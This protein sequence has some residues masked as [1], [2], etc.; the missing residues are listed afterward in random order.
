[1]ESA[2]EECVKSLLEK[3]QKIGTPG[4]LSKAVKRGSAALVKMV[5]DR[6]APANAGDQY[7]IKPLETALNRGS[8]RLL[9]GEHGWVPEIPDNHEVIALLLKA[10]AD[11]KTKNAQG[12]S[13]FG[14]LMGTGSD[15]KALHAMLDQG[16][17]PSCYCARSNS[18]FI[19]FFYLFEGRWGKDRHALLER[20]LKT[21]AP[22]DARYSDGSGGVIQAA[23]EHGDRRALEL[24]KQYGAK[25][26]EAGR[27]RWIYQLNRAI[28]E[29]RKNLET[30]KYY[31]SML[32]QLEGLANIK[33]MQENLEFLLA[34]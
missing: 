4:L 26:K 16:A 11:F 12:T 29:A 34:N 5:L 28:D 13:P 15:A 7:G 25:F 20:L 24:L 8:K 9:L 30:S 23:L 14:E 32:D 6:K 33:R 27:A 17:D 21:G 1:M 3:S 22:V 31:V 19:G 10:G 2:T 18:P